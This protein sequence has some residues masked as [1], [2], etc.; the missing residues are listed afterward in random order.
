MCGLK[1]KKVKSEKNRKKMKEKRIK[2]LTR[3][4]YTERK[5][6]WVTAGRGGQMESVVGIWVGTDRGTAHMDGNV[7]IQ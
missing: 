2:K 7:R 5:T 6:W 3:A 1:V 4:K